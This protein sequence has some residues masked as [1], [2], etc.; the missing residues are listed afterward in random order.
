MFAFK[1]NGEDSVLAIHL[2]VFHYLLLTDPGESE[3]RVFEHPH[4]VA[5]RK[6]DGMG[7]IKE[8]LRAGLENS[9]WTTV[10]LSLGIVFRH[11]NDLRSS[12]TLQKS[13][14]IGLVELLWEASKVSDQLNDI[15]RASTMALVH[16]FLPESLILRSIVKGCDLTELRSS[17]AN[18][19]DDYWDNILT[20][21][22]D[23][24]NVYKAM[25]IGILSLY[26]RQVDFR[27]NESPRD[28]GS[29][30]ITGDTTSITDIAA[31][32]EI[33]MS[34]CA[35]RAP[36]LRAPLSSDS[37]TQAL[38]S[39][40]TSSFPSEVE[41]TPM[42]QDTASNELKLTVAKLDRLETEIWQKIIE[43]V[44]GESILE[45]T[46]IPVDL[47]Y[48]LRANYGRRCPVARRRSIQSLANICLT[49]RFLWDQ[50]R[51]HRETFPYAVQQ[52]AK[53]EADWARTLARLSD[54]GFKT[55][56]G[57]NMRDI[58][59]TQK[60]I[61]IIKD[62]LF[63]S[64]SLAHFAAGFSVA[65]REDLRLTASLK[66]MMNT[67]ID[68]N[69]DT[70]RSI[71][72][73]NL[74]VD[75]LIHLREALSDTLSVLEMLYSH[76][77]S[78]A[79]VQ[80]ANQEF[81][82]WKR[83]HSLSLVNS[84]RVSLLLSPIR[85]LLCDHFPGVQFLELMVGRGEEWEVCA[86]FL[87]NF[88]SL[89]TLVFDTHHIK[90]PIRNALPVLD[91]VTTVAL[92]WLQVDLVG[93]DFTP[94]ASTIVLLWVPIPFMKRSSMALKTLYDVML[95]IA[96]HKLEATRYIKLRAVR[97]SAIKECTWPSIVQ[98]D[99]IRAFDRMQEVGIEVL[100][101]NGDILTGEDFKAQEAPQ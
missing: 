84:S 77:Y 44:R 70:L 100:D 30:R 72:W 33:S 11:L 55:I 39:T 35:L 89:R 32:P 91:S 98:T 58:N 80:T 71:R 12:N 51:F 43:F 21:H 49:C 85:L 25:L 52:K 81:R 48:P 2:G 101:H 7:V 68:H 93:L 27:V 42:A 76:Q 9:K 75:I 66:A 79:D 10:S 82:I 18:I 78:Y 56:R 24:K 5:L 40:L 20:V 13:L 46:D 15:G 86:K 28:D 16:E 60:K 95:Y 87:K 61:N 19:I 17:P 65:N 6:L 73:T 88:P 92:P 31:A 83:L 38:T 1:I 37:S 4:H 74:N 64:P 8:I 22:E 54:S 47:S 23:R 41:E 94:N 62:I 97:L 57:W 45:V 69:R 90:E 34:E 63:F 36:L 50:I 3:I 26:V 14:E 96:K 53:T 29:T 59:L 67:V 99:G